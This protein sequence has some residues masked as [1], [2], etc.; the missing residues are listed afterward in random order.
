MKMIKDITEHDR[1]KWMPG[2]QWCYAAA[3]NSFHRVKEGEI[4]TRGG[5]YYG[6]TR[7]PVTADPATAGCLWKLVTDSLKGDFSAL[8]VEIGFYP[9][10]QNYCATIYDISGK[11]V[12]QS[13]AGCL[14][15]AAL[16]VLNWMWIESR[17]TE[18]E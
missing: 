4:W 10:E 7:L 6:R 12:F 2:M 3:P 11:A 14:G 13:E 5:A 15:R 16:V 8:T 9:N 18:Q 17:A 1:W